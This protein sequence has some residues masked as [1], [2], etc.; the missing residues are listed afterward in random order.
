MPLA[1]TLHFGLD[2]LPEGRS[3]PK[4]MKT[5]EQTGRCQQRLGVIPAAEAVERDDRN[6]AFEIKD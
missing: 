4:T 5:Q 3:A 2:S 6:T 1:F